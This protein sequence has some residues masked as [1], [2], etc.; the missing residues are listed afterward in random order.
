MVSVYEQNQITLAGFYIDYI[1]FKTK[2][3]KIQQTL[4]K[5]CFAYAF[6]FMLCVCGT[7]TLFG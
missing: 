3:K 7:V 4:L 1:Q 5:I 2:N 6:L